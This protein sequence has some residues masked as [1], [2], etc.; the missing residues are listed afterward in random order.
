MSAFQLPE[1]HLGAIAKWAIRNNR[2]AVVRSYWQGASRQYTFEEICTVLAAEC[3][4]SVRTRYPDGPLPGPSY[5]PDG[6]VRFTMAQSQYATL[7]PIDVLKACASYAYQSCET[8]DWDESEAF[9]LIESIKHAAIR[10][11]PGYDESP[12]WV[13]DY[14]A[15]EQA[16]REAEARRAHHRAAQARA[17]YINSQNH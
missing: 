1:T 6:P 17:D 10:A 5:A 15:S 14:D 2:G 11:L 4:R 16:E 7:Q 12:A 9:A 8:N 3:F 13:V